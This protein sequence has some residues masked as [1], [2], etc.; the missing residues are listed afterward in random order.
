MSGCFEVGPNA[1]KVMR[2]Q[3]IEAFFELTKC[4]SHELYFRSV[5]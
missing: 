5:N 1:L 4:N 3:F 2:G